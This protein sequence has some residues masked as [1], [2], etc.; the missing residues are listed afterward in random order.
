V[1]FKEIGNRA[2]AK[3]DRSLL[4]GW[5]SGIGHG[6]ECLAGKLLGDLGEVGFPSPHGAPLCD[7]AK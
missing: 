2:S 4:R 5:A 6:E 1:F 7:R 3:L